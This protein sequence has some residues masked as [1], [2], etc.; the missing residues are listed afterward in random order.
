MICEL[1]LSRIKALTSSRKNK[2]TCQCL[3]YSHDDSK[4]SKGNLIVK[5]KCINY[6]RHERLTLIHCPVNNLILKIVVISVAN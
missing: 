6:D 3:T 2:L 4:I 5:Q 1:I